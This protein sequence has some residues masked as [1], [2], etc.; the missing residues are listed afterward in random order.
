M[1]P[2]QIHTYSFQLS[3]VLLLP[4][5]VDEPLLYAYY[6]FHGPK[7]RKMYIYTEKNSGTKH[8]GSL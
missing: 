7:K 2:H 1:Q 8:Y 4:I 3:V 5:G 6:L